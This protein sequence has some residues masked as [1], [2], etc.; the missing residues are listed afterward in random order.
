MH[1][2]YLVVGLVCLGVASLKQTPTWAVVI[3]IL[4]S[5]GLFL[6]WMLSWMASRVGDSTRNEMQIL[7]ADELRA[8]RA[9]AEARKAA[10]AAPPSVPDADEPP[11]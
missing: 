9:Q 3:L 5:L 11:G 10:A 6:A 1:W 4:G 7:S 2:L 8:M